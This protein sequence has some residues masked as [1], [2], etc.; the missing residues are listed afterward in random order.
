MSSIPVEITIRGILPSTKYDKM[1]YAVHLRDTRNDGALE[2]ERALST[3]IAELAPIPL[4][5]FS[6]TGKVVVFNEAAHGKFEWMA[7]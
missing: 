3:T 2:R 4:V 7:C 6:W 5:Q 1:Q